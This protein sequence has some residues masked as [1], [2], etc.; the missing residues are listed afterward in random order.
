MFDNI[1]DSA[2]LAL[3]VA[4]DEVSFDDIAATFTEVTGKKAVHQFVPMEEYL[5]TAEPYPN[6][7]ANWAAGPT[8][9]RDESTMTWRENFRAW[10]SFWGEGLPEKRNWAL[11]DKIHPQ[12]VKSLKEWMEK[13]SYDGQHKSVL[14]G[15]DDLRKWAQAQAEAQAKTDKV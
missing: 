9:P 14:K 2:G 8:A 5:P 13:N 4:T 15:A 12:R 6:A 11:L 7:P 10:W 3:K 1:K